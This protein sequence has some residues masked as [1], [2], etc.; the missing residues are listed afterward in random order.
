MQ[1]LEVKKSWRKTCLHLVLFQHVK[2]ESH[3]LVLNGSEAARKSERKQSRKVSWHRLL[4]ARNGRVHIELPAGK[5]F[6][7][8]EEEMG[9][10]KE[11]NILLIKSRVAKSIEAMLPFLLSTSSSSKTRLTV[12]TLIVDGNQALTL[13]ISFF[14]RIHLYCKATQGLNLRFSGLPGPLTF[15]WFGTC[16]G[17]IWLRFSRRCSGADR[18][19]SDY[20]MSW[21]WV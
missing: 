13:K 1:Q 8:V 17:A 10:V 9:W 11:V 3:I 12:K 14:S 5:N 16:K 20:Q 7:S 2:R 6:T 19:G 18:S 15:S 21:C 4:V